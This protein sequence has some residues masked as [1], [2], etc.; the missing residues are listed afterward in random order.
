MGY[1][2][3]GT[4][5]REGPADR[6]GAGPAQAETSCRRAVRQ[7]ASV[8]GSPVGV[9]GADVP[10]RPGYHAKASIW[11][12]VI[13]RWVWTSRAFLMVPTHRLGLLVSLHSRPV[14]FV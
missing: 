9:S 1:K 2:T 14:F 4:H 5:Q 11:V 13:R 8:L 10:R 6:P 12:W 7:D 3:A